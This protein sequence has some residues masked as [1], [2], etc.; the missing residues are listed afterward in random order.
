VQT[1]KFQSF[2]PPFKGP[3]NRKN[4]WKNNRNTDQCKINVV[5]D[6]KMVGKKGYDQRK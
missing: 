2:F 5:Y 1:Q 4:Q 6:F 3:S